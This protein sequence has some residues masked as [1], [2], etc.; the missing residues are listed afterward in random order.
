MAQTIHITDPEIVK[1]VNKF[2]KRENRTP[3]NA[4]R[5][6]IRRAFCMQYPVESISEPVKNFEISSVGQYQDVPVPTE[7]AE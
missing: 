1:L 5:E 2:A 3:H 6:M 7:M 4:V